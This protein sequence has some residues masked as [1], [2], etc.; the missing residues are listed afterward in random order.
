MAALATVRAAKLAIDASVVVLDE[1]NCEQPLQ[2]IVDPT[3]PVI[4]PSNNIHTA[5]TTKET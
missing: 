2:S 5:R 3:K 1:A 4:S